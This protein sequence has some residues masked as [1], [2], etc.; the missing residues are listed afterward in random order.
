M[1]FSFANALAT[2]QSMMNYIFEDLILKGQVIV[3]L[4]NILIFENNKEEYKTIV[5]EV[6]SRLLNNNLFAK[7]EKC[8]FLRKS[9]DY[10][11][12]II[13]KGYISMDKKKISGVLEWPVP[14]KVK[15]I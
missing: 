6:L 5:L 2:F 11:R 1:Y 13:S 9:I 3:Y 7:A 15:Y 10:L 14:I 8:F 12:I 4:D